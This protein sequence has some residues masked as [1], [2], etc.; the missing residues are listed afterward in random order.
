MDVV[1]YPSAWIP[2]RI[3]IT[4][5]LAVMPGWVQ[6]KEVKIWVSFS[7]E[8]IKKMINFILVNYYFKG[9]IED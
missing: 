9:N 5:V 2:S 1:S 8:N 6:E 4:T 7:S 3:F